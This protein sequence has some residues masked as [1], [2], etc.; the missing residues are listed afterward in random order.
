[1]RSTGHSVPEAD[2]A[3]LM[4][5]LHDH[6]HLLGKYD[7]TLSPEMAQGQLRPLRDPSSLQESLNQ[8]PWRG[9]RFLVSGHPKESGQ[10]G[11][12]LMKA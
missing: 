6:R 8:I 9:F 2:V 11:P 1:M 7:F 10:C 4:P 3:R 12:G 5:L